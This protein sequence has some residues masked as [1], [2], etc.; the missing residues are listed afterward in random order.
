M[1]SFVII[2]VLKKIFIE[3]SS[4][5]CRTG[6]IIISILVGALVGFALFTTRYTIDKITC[7]HCVSELLRELLII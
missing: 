5:S 7:K 2:F 3:D 1:V 6:Y 4:C